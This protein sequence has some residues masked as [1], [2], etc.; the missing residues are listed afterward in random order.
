MKSIYSFN[1]ETDKE[2]SGYAALSEI[3]GG[4]Q[5]AL[6]DTYGKQFELFSMNEYHFELWTIFE[7][8]MRDEGSEVEHVTKIYEKLESRTF[9]YDGE[10][11]EPI[12]QVQPAL[13]NNLYAYKNAG[14]A[15]ARVP[16][17]DGAHIGQL[18]CV[19]AVGEHEMKTF[20]QTLRDRLWQ[21]SRNEV[22]MFKDGMDGLQQEHQPVTRT[23]T[24][25]DV[26]L[27]EEMK[28]EIYQM[29]D[30]FFEEDRSFF[31]SYRIPYRR[32]ILLYGPP[33]NG[34]T[35]LVKSIAHTVDAPVAYWQITEFTSSD[36]IAQVFQVAA[37]LAPMILVIE[38]ID[39][40]PDGVRSYFLN[41]LDGATSKEGIFL[42]GTTN[43]PERIDPGLINRAG[44][45]DRGYEVKLPGEELR[46]RYTVKR[47][48]QSVMDEQGLDLAIR[49][50]EGFSFA[51]LSELFIAC[52][53]E[54]HQKGKVDVGR[55][56]ESM[57]SEYKKSK[58]G[59]WWEGNDHLGFR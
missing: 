46:K 39:S 59:K 24:R 21:K 42:V 33:G 51:Q 40:M 26:V 48:F 50:T 18:E 27:N 44:R 22:L 55:I 23:V 28:T 13:Q 45:F 6:F 36:S 25:D 5:E 34:K 54:K 12:Y 4:M 37:R 38:D 32:G 1:R 41:T 30:H 15:F 35:T 49:H 53:L 10:A 14:I 29:L 47:N 31:T 2:L 19:L 56:I 3:I 43:Y 16:I 58:T 8:D 11:Q 17:F 57:R 9:T 7:E 20:L 52:A